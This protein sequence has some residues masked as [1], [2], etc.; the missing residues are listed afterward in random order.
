[1]S[2]PT[3]KFDLVVFD[4][5]GTTVVDDDAVNQCLGGAL[6]SGSGIRPTRD[7]INAVMGIQK[8][9]AIRSLLRDLS[10]RDPDPGLVDRIHDAFRQRMLDYYRSDPAVREIDGVG[11]TFRKIRSMGIRI[12][13]DTGFDRPIASVIF[14]RLGWIKD[15]LVDASVTADEVVAGRPAPFMI[16]RLMELTQVHVVGRVAK[17]GDTPSDLWE[18]TNA[19]CGL[20]AGVTG[21]SHSAQQLAEHPHTHLV[22][23]CTDLLPVLV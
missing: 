7:A 16:F 2:K 18:G 13:I 21:G 14:D 19:G 1:M 10:G 4:M 12:G 8:P 17:V 3:R 9:V 15:G 22:R 6:E 23:S 20:V 5:A 11:E